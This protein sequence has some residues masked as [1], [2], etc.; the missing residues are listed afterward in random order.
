M[1]AELK[2]VTWHNIDGKVVGGIFLKTENGFLAIRIFQSEYYEFPDD[3]KIED[4]Y[5]DLQGKI[6]L[7]Q[8]GK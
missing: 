7:E 3:A 1:L 8:S 2:K 5:I 6:K 4:V